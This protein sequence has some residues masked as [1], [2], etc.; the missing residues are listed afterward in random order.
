MNLDIVVVTQ[1]PDR[2]K[3]KYLTHGI[4]IKGQ[5]YWFFFVMY[6]KLH[7]LIIFIIMYITLRHFLNIKTKQ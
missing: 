2:M 4:Y 6:F 1:L 3:Q 5:V 7:Y